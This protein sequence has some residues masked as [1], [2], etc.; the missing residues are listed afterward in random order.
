MQST[1]EITYEDCGR[2]FKLN[3][4]ADNNNPS[5][6]S[7][8][9][10]NWSDVD[11]SASGLGEPTLIGSGL[12]DAGHWWKV[13]DDVVDDPDGPLTFIKV[14]N[15]QERALGH[16]R[17]RFDDALHNTVGTTACFNGPKGT[18]VGGAHTD[19]PAIGRIRHLGTRFDLTNDPSGG[20]PI[21]ANSE[22]AG[23]TGGFGWMMQLD[24][25]SPKTLRIDQ[26]EVDPS[27]PLVFTMPY[28]AGTSFTITANAYQWCS[29]S[30]THSCQEVFTEVDS[31]SKVRFGQGN[32]YFYDTS[33]NL[34]YVR[35]TQFPE[36]YVGDTLGGESSPTWR[37]W[38]MSDPDTRS[39][40]VA[41]Y[42]LN[43]F[44]YN[45]VTLPK[46]W[47]NGWLEINANCNAG[48]GSLYCPMPQGYSVQ[49][50]ELCPSGYSQTAYDK[51]CLASDLTTCY[52]FTKPPTSAPTSP[53]TFDPNS[54]LVVNGD[55]EALNGSGQ[56]T[57]SPWYMNSGKPAMLE[58]Q[59]TDRG[60]SAL[61]KDRTST[62]NGVEQT[63]P[64]E[65]IQKGSYRL[66]CYSKIQSGATTDF[67]QLTLRIT[68]AE[69]GFTYPG[70][71]TRT[72]I[73]N[74][75]WTLVEGVVS[76]DVPGTITEVKVYAQSP[77]LGTNYYVDDVSVVLVS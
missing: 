68:T 4:F 38:T 12:T 70:W 66:S 72:E 41:P 60:M 54:N 43:R 42:A 65:A 33:T 55:F 15:G 14:N 67:L 47:Y 24:A 20:L 73:N 5:S 39:W 32:V 9:D 3:D 62:W 21:T 51:C 49:S 64:L 57:L 58:L 61:N 34:L 17:F 76:T 2:R 59:P 27:S 53:P 22:V 56:P 31:L 40:S 8:R 6:V 46:F 13:E 52:E 37:L 7:G 48:S 63:L 69:Y 44:S 77:A 26:I 45:G 36:G 19:C 18:S 35:V 11:G 74:N 71:E 23:V 25:G 16:L 28:P 1:R 50:I 10:Q 75:D 30:S 29:P